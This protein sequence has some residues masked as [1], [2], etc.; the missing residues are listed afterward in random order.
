MILLWYFIDC[1]KSHNFGET[2]D[3]IRFFVIVS[4]HYFTGRVFYYNKTFCFN[5]ADLLSL[6]IKHRFRWYWSFAFSLGL[7]LNISF[8]YIGNDSRLVML[9]MFINSWVHSP[10]LEQIVTFRLKPIFNDAPNY[11]EM[12]IT[13]FTSVYCFCF[14]EERTFLLG[15]FQEYL[16]SVIPGVSFVEFYG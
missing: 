10:I 8:S 6:E 7:L 12:H 13:Y 4:N 3:F 11:Y 16:S 9:D 2:R 14:Y 15:S 5:M 1:V